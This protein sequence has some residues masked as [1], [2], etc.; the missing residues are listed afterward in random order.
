MHYGEEHYFVLERV[1]VYSNKG[2]DSLTISQFK[3]IQ[4]S[5]ALETTLV[6]SVSSSLPR[7]M[8]GLPQLTVRFL[9][10]L[11]V[12]V[13]RFWLPKKG[14]QLGK[15]FQLMSS[16][17]AYLASSFHSSKLKSPQKYMCVPRDLAHSVFP[18]LDFPIRM[19][20]RGRSTP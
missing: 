12:T 8:H 6:G 10:Y 14:F 17:T 9:R 11:S 4:S 16:K 3:S 20:E 1:V 13:K 7:T 5:S 2:T 18:S 19:S 15:N